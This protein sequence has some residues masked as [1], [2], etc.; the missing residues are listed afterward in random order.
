VYL[1]PGIFPSS[2]WNHDALAGFPPPT[3]YSW[4]ERETF[5]A[6][7][8]DFDTALAHAQETGKPILIDFTGW[9]CVN[10]RQMEE[11][12]WT[13]EEVKRMLEEDFVLVSLYVDDKNEL[14][15]EQQGVFEFDADG[16]TRKK[17]IKTIGNKWATFQT[18]VFNNNSQPYYVMLSPEGELLGYPIGYTPDLISYTEYLKC[19]VNAHA[20]K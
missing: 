2:P 17:K 8:D 9:A 16:Q 13:D 7:Y 19:G 10:C 11:T 6:E 12:I 1:F 3:F 18:H 5:H 15:E 20:A 14:P 4:Y